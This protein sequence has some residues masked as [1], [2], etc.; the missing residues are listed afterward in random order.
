MRLRK[1]FI[2]YLS[3][4]IVTILGQH[5]LITFAE[6]KACVELVRFTIVNELALE[7]ELDDE[8]IDILEEQLMKLPA[9]ERDNL[10]V[11]E[12]F[13]MIKR[14]LIRERNLIV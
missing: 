3:E 12:L 14:Q 13:K 5:D 1:D 2:D 6:L 10:D 4:R 9:R 11:D 8:V 7:D